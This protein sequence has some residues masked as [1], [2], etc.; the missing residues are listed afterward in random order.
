MGNT[1]SR[2][3][4]YIANIMSLRNSFFKNFKICAST[5]QYIPPTPM[6]FPTSRILN[7]FPA[8]SAVRSTVLSLKGDERKNAQFGK[9]RHADTENFMNFMGKMP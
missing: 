8:V 2:H 7:S 3:A 5:F 6:L 9:S 4:R 1:L